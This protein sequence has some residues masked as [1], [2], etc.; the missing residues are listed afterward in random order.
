MLVEIC[1]V[2][3]GRVKEAA[4][5]QCPECGSNL[6]KGYANEL[7]CTGLDE[8]GI[9][10]AYTR[11]IISLN[12][13]LDDKVTELVNQL[14]DAVNAIVDNPAHRL[15]RVNELRKERCLPPLEKL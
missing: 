9:R 13:V 6:I 2:D 3:F 15:K 12:L 10:C 4:D 8:V 11:T 5:T 14:A 1:E 7:R